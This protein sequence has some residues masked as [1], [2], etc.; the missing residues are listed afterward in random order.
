VPTRRLRPRL[1][2]MAAVTAMVAT[3][4]AILPSANAAAEGWHRVRWHCQ[5]TSAGNICGDI[6]QYGDTN[7]HRFA[8]HV[9]AKDGHRIRVKQEITMWKRGFEVE[10]QNLCASACPSVSGRWISGF[11][12]WRGIAFVQNGYN[13]ST[14]G[15]RWMQTGVSQAYRQDRK[16]ETT[17]AGKACL[18]FWSRI[19]DSRFFVFSRVGLQPENGNW[20]APTKASVTF[21]DDDAANVVTYSGRKTRGWSARNPDLPAGTEARFEVVSRF[22]YRTAAGERAL[23]IDWVNCQCGGERTPIRHRA[24]G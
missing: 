18:S 9:S 19:V 1:F 7:Q 20:M 4:T 15:A 3:L 12:H 10:R 22:Y 11:V 5:T 17:R 8:V 23:R 14:G 16:C 13:T 2:A 21:P 6:Q 24:A